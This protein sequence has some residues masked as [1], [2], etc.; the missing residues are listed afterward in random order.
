MTTDIVD[1]L[2][3]SSDCETGCHGRCQECPDERQR[4]A[5]NEIVRLRK[6]LN[7]RD[8]AHLENPVQ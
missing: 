6:L 1:R 2:L 3:N 7:D 5:A 8:A 4:E